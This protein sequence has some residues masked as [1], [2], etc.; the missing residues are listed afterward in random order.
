MPY[1]RVTE[2]KTVVL[3]HVI[4]AASKQ[5]AHAQMREPLHRGLVSIITDECD[6]DYESYE[7]VRC[8]KC[9]GSGVRNESYCAT[10]NGEGYK[11]K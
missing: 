8:P 3:T 2:I 10:C 5:D 11:V 4:E 1:F 6:T 9:N 7:V